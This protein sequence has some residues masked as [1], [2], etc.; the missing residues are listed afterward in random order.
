MW[1]LKFRKRSQHKECSFCHDMR[2][3]LLKPG[4]GTAQK[5]QWAWEWQEHL[6]AQYHD[7]LIY[8]SLRWASRAKMNALTIL[9][10]GTDKVKTAWP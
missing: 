10:D 2:E 6:R 1:F 7:R 9:I 5:M 3:N 4:Q 8:W